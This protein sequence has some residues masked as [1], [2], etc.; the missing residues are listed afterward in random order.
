MEN[1]NND[2]YSARHYPGYR[3]EFFANL[4]THHNRRMEKASYRQVIGQ[5][6]SLY[7]KVSPRGCAQNSK[8][9]YED[10]DRARDHI[11]IKQKE[12][13]H[14]AETEISKLNSPIKLDNIVSSSTRKILPLVSPSPV[15][16]LED[17]SR[18]QAKRKRIRSLE[19][20][21]NQCEI[22]QPEILP[23]RKQLTNHGFF[24]LSSA[25]Y[26]MNYIQ[27]LEVCLKQTDDQERI[28]NMMSTMYYNRITDQG[29]KMELKSMK[30]EMLQ[31]TNKLIKMS[32]YKLWRHN[33]IG[34]IS[35]TDKKI[36]SLPIVKA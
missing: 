22:F 23:Q 6:S 15:K 28:K 34:I 4:A 10:V 2:E 8:I 25:D 36:A 17:R 20:V 3:S 26:A 7:S 32:G 29:L 12:I 11:K 31:T 16:R 5:V 14:Y 30:G 19:A 9:H 24:R 35:A 13:S 18:I 27:D 33:N 21:I 1:N